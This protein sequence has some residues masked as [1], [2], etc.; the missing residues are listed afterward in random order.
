MVRLLLIVFLSACQVGEDD[1]SITIKLDPTTK[2]FEWPVVGTWSRS[3][4]WFRLNNLE[5]SCD[6]GPVGVLYIGQKYVEL[7]RSWC[8][9]DQQI[10][11]Q[12]YPPYGL[13]QIQTEGDIQIYIRREQ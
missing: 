11:Y 10:L 2:K 6:S 8:G 13:L 3:D 5:I 7:E 4:N 1:N 9:V 12:I